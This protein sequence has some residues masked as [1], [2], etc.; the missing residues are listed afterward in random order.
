MVVIAIIAILAAILFPVFAKAR[1]KARTASCASNLKQLGNAMRMYVDDYD[2]L[3]VSCA[4]SGSSPAVMPERQGARA[5]WTDH[6]YPYVKSGAV[7]VCPSS[8]T[9]KPSPT[10]GRSGGYALNWVYFANFSAP[11][12][13]DS[14]EQPAETIFLVDTNGVSSGYYCAGGQGGPGNNWAR[15]W[16]PPNRHNEMVNIAWLDGHV[17]LK[18]PEVILDDS[19]NAN[20]TSATIVASGGRNPNPANPALTSYWDMD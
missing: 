13:I 7:Y 12:P 9:D 11:L 10:Y 18:R 15:F 6:L 14:V 20:L 17:S 16:Y 3:S 4:I 5:D 19:R 1:E 8:P 2:G